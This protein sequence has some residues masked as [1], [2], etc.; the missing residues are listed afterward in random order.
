[1]INYIKQDITTI[2]QGIVAHGCNCKGVMGAGVAKAIR[3]KWPLAYQEYR[4]LCTRAFPDSL[5]ATCQL[6]EINSHLLIANLFTQISYGRI[7]GHQYATMGAIGGSVLELVERVDGLNLPIYM[8]RIGAGLGGLN[9]DRQVEPIVSVI[10][11]EYGIT[12]NVC[13]L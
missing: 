7:P 5:L 12:I 8:P 10:A 9:W 2:E 3:T 11:Q 6:V 4:D 1:M 13:D